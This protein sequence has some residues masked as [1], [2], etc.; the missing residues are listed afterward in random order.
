MLLKSLEEWLLGI[1]ALNSGQETSST[2]SDS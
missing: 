1:L 2:Y